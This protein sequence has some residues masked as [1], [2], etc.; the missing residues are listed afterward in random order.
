MEPVKGG[1]LANLP[2]KAKELLSKLDKDASQ[3]SWAI[4]FA[5]SVKDSFTVLSG[6][7]SLEQIEDNTS[8]MQEFIPLSAEETKA[9][10]KVVDIINEVAPIPCTG[11]RYCVEGC[12]AKVSIPECFS[13]YNADLQYMDNFF[14]PHEEVYFNIPDENKPSAC[15]GCGQCEAACPQHLEV[16]K[17]LKD[18]AKRFEQ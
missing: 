3:A 11:C 4:R 17:L 5:A 9:V 8:Y 2:N 7:S 18:V 16:M 10:F 12:P 13:I 6:M 14:S 1:T 15:I